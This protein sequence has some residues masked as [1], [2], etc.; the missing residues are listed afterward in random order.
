ME[1]SIVLYECVK[2]C[3]GRISEARN[4]I[5]GMKKSAYEGST[6]QYIIEFNKD[7]IAGLKGIAIKLGYTDEN[8]LS[9]FNTEEL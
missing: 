8:Y 6:G 3:R 7:L 9:E 1:D 4:A 5:N 2:K